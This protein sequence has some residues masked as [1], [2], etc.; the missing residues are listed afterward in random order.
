[1]QYNRFL[2]IHLVSSEFDTSTTARSEKLQSGGK[3]YRYDFK[4]D[5]QSQMDA[6][7]SKK[8]RALDDE[9]S[10]FLL[11]GAHYQA[12]KAEQCVV[13]EVLTTTSPAVGDLER[14]HYAAC[15][16]DIKSLKPNE[17][18]LDQL[19]ALIK[20]VSAEKLASGAKNTGKLRLNSHGS[21]HS[22]AEL[23]MGRSSLSPDDLVDALIR[24]GLGTRGE[25]FS[26]LRP[27][28]LKGARWKLDSEVEAC[29]KC[30]NKFTV[31]RRRH[32][33]RRCGGIFCDTCTK[34]RRRLRNPLTERGTA[35]GFMNDCRVCDDCASK[36]DDI[37]KRTGLVQLTL[38]LCLSAR[39]SNE[40][41]EMKAGFARNSIAARLLAALKKN[42]IHGVQVSGSNEV[43]AWCQKNNKFMQQF[44]VKYPGMGSPGEPKTSQPA[45]LGGTGGLGTTLT[46][47]SQSFPDSIL[48]STGEPMQDPKWPAIIH[49]AQYA[50]VSN[51]KIVPICGGNKM[52]FGLFQK[53]SAEEALVKKVFNEWGFHS[54]RYQELPVSQFVEFLRPINP[55]VGR[56]E[57]GTAF[58]KAG[59]VASHQKAKDIAWTFVIDAPL[60]RVAIKRDPQNSSQT[61]SRLIVSGLEELRFKEH[62]VFEVS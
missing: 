29:E 8:T 28:E 25:E 23:T 50:K 27:K 3:D 40:F 45:A 57:A 36:T 7:T 18:A 24:H 32:H 54:W 51:L 11:F 12:P 38:A 15:M 2:E 48:G 1:M 56:Q 30:R 34:Q 41:A 43:V 60:R 4:Y 35:T 9:T 42:G 59:V 21:S 10:P 55:A 31:L 6:Y 52:A 53:N 39:S 44:Y 58:F 17:K 26:T 46:E 61:S 20:W 5:M 49:N 37:E 14:F 33:C 13:E 62:K 22:G 16:V 47:V 19:T